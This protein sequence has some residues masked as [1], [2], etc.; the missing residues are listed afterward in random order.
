MSLS[1]D[2]NRPLGRI[3]LV[4]GALVA[5]VVTYAAAHA[6]F[7]YMTETL[8]HR[9]LEKKKEALRAKTS[10]AAF[11]KA[12]SA[13][14]GKNFDAVA[15]RTQ[16]DAAASDEVKKQEKE[17]HHES[18]ATWGPFSIFLLILSGVLGS[19]LLSVYVQRRANDAGLQGLWLAPN[20]LGAWAVGCFI[21]F[22][23]YLAELGATKAWAPVPV[24]G[25]LL[26]L[27]VLLAGSS[28]HHHHHDHDHGHDH[29]HGHGHDHS[30]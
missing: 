15:A 26:L 9:G 1:L 3:G 5:A 22:T 11:A 10:D 19:G 8:P 25:G 20:H 14:K 29:G 24:V 12:K 28:G 17:L 6:S 7:H 4:L 16:A 2:L 13:A 18:E 30:H 27:P 21:A 23:P